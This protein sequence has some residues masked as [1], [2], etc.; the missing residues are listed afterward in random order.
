LAF[1][2][3]CKNCGYNH[4]RR[5]F[6]RATLL[7]LIDGL[8]INRQFIEFIRNEGIIDETRRKELLVV[9]EKETSR[10]H[11]MAE[12]SLPEVTSLN[13]HTS[14]KAIRKQGQSSS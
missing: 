2:L 8:E 14:I 3:L 11:E 4:E 9:S 6:I 1:R 10:P 5:D 12:K 7:H 13:D